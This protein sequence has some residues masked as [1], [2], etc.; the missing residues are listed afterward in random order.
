MIGK[1][2][3]GGYSPFY[4][5]L[6]RESPKPSKNRLAT[7]SKTSKPVPGFEL[8]LLRKNA[9]ALPFTPPPLPQTKPTKTTEYKIG[10]N[11]T[12]DLKK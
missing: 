10:H 7:F 12:T 4:D 8:S 11:Q 1:K 9:V 6:F 2:R 5:T 3:E